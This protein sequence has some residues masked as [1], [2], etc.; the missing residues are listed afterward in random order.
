MWTI[1][2]DKVRKAFTDAADQYDILTSLHKEIGRELVKKTARLDA[3]R[4]LDVGCGTGYVANK[5]KF[6]FPESAI[7]GLDLS[8][9]MLG[10]ARQLH[11]GIPIDWVQADAQALPFKA[12]TFDLLLSSLAYQWAEDL[13][14]AFQ[15]AYRILRPGAVFNITLFGGRTCEELFLSLTANNPQ[16]KARSLPGVDQ[17]REALGRAGF[18]HVDIDF[19]LIKIEF[20]N[21]FELLQ[22]LK[23]IGANT[24][25]LDTIFLGKQML[26]RV[27]EYYH[28]HFPYNA[29][30]CASF[31]VIWAYAQK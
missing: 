23:A 26:A 15:E 2:T 21:V 4:I 24:T 14:A 3:A 11:E 8:E 10:K 6:F 19:E 12:E 20:K 9:G 25:D 18:G 7:V 16:F 5:A 1:F 29:G 27:D 28:K 22:W 30:I 17:T 13:S 31:E